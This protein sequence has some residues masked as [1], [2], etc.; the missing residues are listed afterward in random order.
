[1]QNQASKMDISM[2]GVEL[3]VLLFGGS[4]DDSL[5]DLRHRNYIKMVATSSC[6]NPSKL[7]P[8]KRSAHIHSLCVRLQ[9][10]NLKI[11]L[12]DIWKIL[13]RLLIEVS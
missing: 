11:Y 7:P 12:V 8:T 4:M 5:E 3:F 6:I 1:M 9:V 2:A 13:V 10:D